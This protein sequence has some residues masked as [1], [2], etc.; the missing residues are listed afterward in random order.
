MKRLFR[1]SKSP[2]VDPLPPPPSAPSSGTSTP[3]HHHHE[4]RWPFG[5]SHQSEV[6][7]FP[8]DAGRDTAGQAFSG[9][10][11][12][13]VPSL[14]EIQQMQE[15]EQ[16]MRSGQSIPPHQAINQPQYQQQQQFQQHSQ[17]R[18]GSYGSA[19]PSPDGW[20][21]VSPQSNATPISSD[22]FDPP[23]HSPSTDPLPI[24]QAAFASSPTPSNASPSS[25][26]THTALYLPPGA[27]P[28]TPPSTRPPYAANSARHSQSSLNSM[29]TAQAQ[30]SGIGK[31]HP[32]DMINMAPPHGQ[33]GR[34]RGHSVAS[35]TGSVSA[36][37]DHDSSPNPQSHPS[38][39][40]LAKSYPIPEPITSFPSPHPYNQSLAAN[41]NSNPNIINIDGQSVTA[42]LDSLPNSFPPSGED[43]T[44]LGPPPASSNNQVQQNSS[45]LFRRAS[46]ADH[47]D[48]KEKK[49]GLWGMGMNWTK[50]KDKEKEKDKL[51]ERRESHLGAEN[52]WP[53]Q[54][55]DESRRSHD[56]WKESES[57]PSST[58]GHSTSHGHEQEEA[59]RGRLLGL[60]FGGGR[61]EK[62]SQ[63]QPHHM[64]DVTTAIHMLCTMQ[65]P[66]LANI[67]EVC[68]RI[69]T[70]VDNDSIAKEAA[71]ALRKE[72]KHGN[73]GERRNAAKVWLI[74][75]RNI[76]IR[77][78]RQNASSRKFFSSMEPILLAPTQKPLV[79][80]ATH[81]LLS[82]I[83]ADLTFSYGMEKGCEGLVEMWKKVKLPQE[84]DFGNPL[85]AD[86][87]IF[88][89]EPMYPNQAQWSHPPSHANS[90]GSR[91]PSSPSLQQLSSAQQTMQAPAIPTRGA[92]PGKFGPGYTDLP[93][94]GEDIR[95]LV[96]E[97][98][99]AKE[100]ARVLTEALVYTRPEELEHKPIIGEFYRKV[101]LAHE[102]LTAQMDWAQAEAARSR[103][104][105]ANLTL[106]SSGNA[107]AALDTTKHDTPE[108]KALATLFEAHSALSEALK[109]HDEL[110]RLGAE[111]KELREVRERS[112]KETR[113][114]RNQPLYNQTGGLAVP[115]TQ[116]QASS[117]RSP[118]PVPHNRL[119]SDP[120]PRISSSP[121]NYDAPLPP[122]GP[123]SVNGTGPFK[124]PYTDAPRSRTPSPDSHPLPHPPRIPGSPGQTRTSS[125]LGRMRMGGPRPLPNPFA[126]AK[127]ASQH[128][129]AP[130]ATGPASTTG[131][132]TPT[133]PGSNGP[134]RNGTGDTPS[135]SGTG[136]TAD[137]LEE[138]GDNLPAVPIKPSRKA[139]GKR[140]AVVDED[141]H[142]DP[143][144]M[145]APNPSVDPRSRPTA[146]GDPNKG[147]SDSEESLTADSLL[148][149]NGK[150]NKPVV[151]AYDAYEE[152]QK[153]LRRAEEALKL[154]GG[155]GG[156]G[157]RGASGI[158]AGGGAGSG[159]DD[160]ATITAGSVE[161]GGRI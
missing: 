6:T 99:A 18:G 17:S 21:V 45:N 110:D 97:C 26:S 136:S 76:Q 32:D 98:T 78:F 46:Q 117:S 81:R 106:D 16:A 120:V 66:P 7:P 42:P 8:V 158:G 139:L 118:S 13:S 79:S 149:P 62:D 116:V 93:S 43:M 92:S 140:R 125:P 122:P 111:E 58:H 28:A 129:L 36:R 44:T 12:H 41:R 53:R 148:N 37:S 156:G 109:Q 9:N 14:L 33:M 102:S 74:L 86:H 3:T 29:S 144:D 108:E 10:G 54:S 105:H 137:D 134:S 161:R 87:P 1:T 100:S 126:N 2:M 35:A 49:R 82:D 150:V 38:R 151:Y 128:S 63:P 115:G 146:D 130:S 5:H 72:F 77:G 84:A 127:N 142:F 20:T 121:R 70:S 15:R 119:P 96:D 47:K 154:S 52:D 160:G 69:N 23:Y 133:V 104:R 4:H 85:P 40:P 132:A 30:Y 114:D 113:M 157:S 80:A 101:F 155:S 147:D 123:G 65:D 39:S 64:S 112:K 22:G 71:R 55:V 103:E 34:E 94:H 27:R 61:K 89:G 107:N 83:L 141:N 19:A 48:G 59:P 11:I 135:R 75:M 124:G 153:E 56:G 90:I 152:R 138:D 131:A 57:Q 60:D 73:E 67:Y 24:P 31:G 51:K 159:G 143:N 91:R 25:A 50:G 88:G 68:D 95:R 145:F